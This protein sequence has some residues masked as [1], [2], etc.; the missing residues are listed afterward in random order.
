MTIC[1]FVLNTFREIIE[2][3][4]VSLIEGCCIFCLT[5]YALCYIISV[6]IFLSSQLGRVLSQLLCS[7][8]FNSLPTRFVKVKACEAPTTPPTVDD[9][10][11]CRTTFFCRDSAGSLY[12]VR[13]QKPQVAI[14]GENCGEI[15]HQKHEST[16]NNNNENSSQKHKDLHGLAWLAYIHTVEQINSNITK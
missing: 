14:I 2:Q 16:I 13:S 1:T 8:I 11:R 9:S 6:T 4:K 12:C 15:K 3:G 7:F 5:F 10:I